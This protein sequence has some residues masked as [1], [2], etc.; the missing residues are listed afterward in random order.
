MG[1]K[2][3]P[4]VPD[5]NEVTEMLGQKLFYPPTVAG[6]AHG[7]SWITP[8]LLL[9]R[10][11]FVYDHGVSRYHFLRPIATGQRLPDRRREREAGDGFGRDD[12]DQA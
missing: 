1:L 5:F 9:A 7:R 10:G 4:G 11:N 8:G 2:E 12:R 6:W 3:I